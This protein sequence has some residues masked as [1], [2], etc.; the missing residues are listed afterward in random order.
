MGDY[1][2]KLYRKFCSRYIKY[3]VKK[4]GFWFV[5]IPR[6]S[7][8][9]IKKILVKKHGYAYAKSDFVSERHCLIKSLACIPPVHM[10]AERC[11]RYFGPEVWHH[12]FTFTLVRNPYDRMVSWWL[13]RKDVVRNIPRHTSFG[14]YIK[15]QLVEKKKRTIT[16]RAA[17]YLLDKDGNILVNY[18]GKYETRERDLKT[19]R[20]KLNAK[21]IEIIFDNTHLYQTPR[22]MK[23]YRQYYDAETRSIVENFFREDIELFDYDF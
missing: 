18:V 16:H 9:S 4:C 12:L 22:A 5:D 20:E 6:T 10:T 15:E 7:G 13:Y 23:S 11:I 17:D 21:G 14:D 3:R 8:T 19:I 1:P 2:P